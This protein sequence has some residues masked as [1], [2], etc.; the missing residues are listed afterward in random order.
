MDRFVADVHLGALVRHLRLLGVDIAY[1]RD[2]SDDRLIEIMQS[3]ARA[4]LTRDRRLLMRAVVNCGYCPRSGVPE[5]QVHEVLRRF[6]PLEL[7]PWSRCLRC[8]GILQPV[9]KR[10]VMAELA[11]EP[12][13]LRYYDDFFRCAG[14]RHVYWR[15]SHADQLAPRLSRLQA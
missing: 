15:G 4:L 2:A 7:S 9:D 12:R 8:N 14:C 5:E 11:A 1:E 3:E 10:E 6:A 13:T